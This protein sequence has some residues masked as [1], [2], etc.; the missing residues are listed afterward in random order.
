M[1]FTYRFVWPIT[2]TISTGHEAQSKV[3]IVQFPIPSL[4][5]ELESS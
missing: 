5:N 1:L 3:Q 4:V 2:D